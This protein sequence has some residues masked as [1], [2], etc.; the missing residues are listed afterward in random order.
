[1]FLE[2]A[3]AIIGIIIFFLP[4]ILASHILF[5]H[6]DIIER[7]IYS[8]ILSVCLITIVCYPFYKYGFQDPNILSSIILILTLILSVLL[9][10]RHK[11]SE[12]KTYY[13]KDILFVLLFS[14]IGGAWR[15]W[16]VNG[17]K[18]FWDA[19]TYAGIS[20]NG[21][22]P[23]LGF[24][25]GMVQSHMNYV[26]IDISKHIISHPLFNILGSQT[27]N[28][29]VTT[30][31]YL[32]MIYLLF[33][34]FR[35]DKALTYA[36]VALMSLGPIEIFHSALAFYGDKLPY[37]ALFSLF[38]L[39][40]S[41]KKNIF[42]LAFFLA[43]YSFLTYY[44]DSMVMILASF[45]FL[46]ALIIK[47][48][49]IKRS[50]SA[51]VK[52]ILKNKKIVGFLVILLLGCSHVFFVSNMKHFTTVSAGNTKQI[53]Q[54]VYHATSR[55]NT[56]ETPEIQT[57]S[58][59]VTKMEKDPVF[60]H[61]YTIYKDPSFLNISALGWQTL[62][63]LFCGFTFIVYLSKKKDFSEENTN[64]LL[65]IIPVTIVS[66]GFLYTGVLTRSF[67]YFVFFGL[68]AVQI[69]KKYY[70]VFLVI[71]SIFILTTSVY[72]LEA[73]RPYF[74]NSEGEVNAAKEMKYFAKGAIFTD[75]TFVN[76]LALNGFY[77]VTGTGDE[78]P[79][80][81]D[82]FY[83]K[84]KTSFLNAIKSL[85]DN[86]IGYIAITKRMRE[87][88]ILM[89]NYPKKSITNSDLYE[90]SLSKIYDNGD[91]RV[92]STEIKKDKNK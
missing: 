40:I 41:K 30:F 8:I 49:F 47:E 9:L 59:L 77:S 7:I 19:Y 38:L 6:C 36:G 46:V 63:F 75:E 11:K 82:L 10:Y 45:G 16:F 90:N 66:F 68:M 78:N 74:E 14:F 29:F 57:E 1:M 17:I 23:D 52:D 51:L 89:L 13:N 62:F 92:Y 83:N 64:I 4:G 15:L 44:T 60:F 34:N 26:G 2:I 80:L 55:P 21:V 50:L 28:I 67:D 24:Y 20:I 81:I 73:K 85:K 61:D 76:N 70:K 65:C 22:A 37:I 43:V 48:F 31:L 53:Q 58:E 33:S 3:L 35:K 32:G 69:P 18:Y 84:N 87:K 54:I 72:A 88:Y 56:K 91:V 71:S 42:W 12:F 86:D 27:L 5:P 79:L 25:T 39:F